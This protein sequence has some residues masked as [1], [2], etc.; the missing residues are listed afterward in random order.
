MV[1]C[2]SPHPQNYRRNCGTC[3]CQ[4]LSCP[5]LQIHRAKSIRRG[6][7]G[8]VPRVTLFEAEEK[9][10]VS[11]PQARRWDKLTTST[12][13]LVP[14]LL[15]L[16]GDKIEE[17]EGGTLAAARRAPARPELAGKVTQRCQWLRWKDAR[18]CGRQG[19]GPRGPR[20]PR[21]PV[22]GQLYIQAP[23][24]AL[25]PALGWVG[26]SASRPP[27]ALGKPGRGEVKPQGP[28]AN[29]G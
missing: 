9:P 29:R 11:K 13:A 8:P 26:D 17:G 3:K 10:E 16:L 14:T 21:G 5:T 6:D 1:S 22:R 28:L 2:P 12:S 23:P 4:K 24:R 20:G 7:S 15:G 25:L 27:A 18:V 19:W